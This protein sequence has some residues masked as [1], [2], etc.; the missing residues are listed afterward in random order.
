[1]ALPRVCKRWARV[2]GRPS[3]AWEHTAI[4]LDKVH[5]RDYS[6]SPLLDARAVSAWFSRCIFSQVACQAAQIGP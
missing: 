5:D 2:L 6:D 3:T 4:D 1:M